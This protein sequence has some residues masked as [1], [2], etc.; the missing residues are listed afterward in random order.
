MDKVAVQLIQISDPHLF[1]DPSIS[2]LYY[3]RN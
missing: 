2:L 3:R 1:G